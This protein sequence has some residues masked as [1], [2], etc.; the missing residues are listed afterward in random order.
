MFLFVP[1]AG[2]KDLVRVRPSASFFLVYLW[3]SII[4]SWF[5]QLF[6]GIQ[7]IPRFVFICVFM[8]LTFHSESFLHETFINPLVVCL[9]EN[10]QTLRLVRPPLGRWVGLPPSGWR[11]G[12]G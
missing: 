4:L 8:L 6:P 10:F 5:C 2:M 12:M 1:L 7:Q 11:D 9:N 3:F